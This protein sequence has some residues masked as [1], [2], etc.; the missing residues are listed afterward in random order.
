MY[1]PQVQLVSNESK[2]TQKAQITYQTPS[3]WWWSRLPLQRREFD[4]PTLPKGWVSL[5]MLIPMPPL[6]RFNRFNKLM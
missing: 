3:P 2:T 5:R 6:K 4:E 1:V